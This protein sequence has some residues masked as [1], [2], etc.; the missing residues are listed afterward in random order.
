MKRT[1]L[2]AAFVTIFIGTLALSQESPYVGQHTRDIKALSG[3]EVE[4]YLDA[5]GMGFAKVAELN[6][7]PG[8]K[9]VLDL[10]DQLDLTDEQHAAAKASF[11][12]MRAAAL[13]LGNELVEKERQLDAL[14]AEGRASEA[15][16]HALIA[17]I[18][19]VSGELR[20]THVRAH[21]EMRDVLTKSQI[22][23]YDELRGYTSP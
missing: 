7:Y 6:H 9:H 14:F 11:R 18:A 8:P 2:V 10:S 4:G 3:A 19:R 21:V 20:H 12:R 5:R 16:A 22:E 13:S 17:E 1:A 15:T 23:R